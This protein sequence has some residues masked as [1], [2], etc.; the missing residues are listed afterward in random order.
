[1]ELTHS[2]TV[3]GSVDDAWRTFMDLEVVGNC[4]PGRP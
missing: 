1:M 3:P 2:F 4:F